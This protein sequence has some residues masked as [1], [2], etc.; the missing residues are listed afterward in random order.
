M[1]AG[2]RVAAIIDILQQLEDAIEDGQRLPADA[3]LHHYTKKRRY[4][5]AKDR[6]EIARVVYLVLRHYAALQYQ[7]DAVGLQPNA[8]TVVLAAIIMLDH[9]SIEDVDVLCEGEDHYCPEVLS[10]K[11]GN[12]LA[13]LQGKPL[14][15]DAQP[16]HVRYNVPA[17]MLPYLDERF[18][19][20]LPQAMKAMAKE[21][22]VD[23]R[24]NTLVT[25]QEKMHYVLEQA[26]FHAH[27]VDLVGTALRMHKRGALFTLPEFQKGWF[28][29]QDAG[30]QYVAH[31]CAVQP[32]EKV[33]DFC[34]GA[35]GK[36]LALAAAMQ[37]KGRIL[38]WDVSPA[39]MR[40]LPRRLKRAGVHNVMVHQ[41]ESEQDS[42]IKRHKQSADCVLV[43]APCTG[44]GT[45]RRAP[46]S[47]W[48]T[49][50]EEIAR[51][52]ELQ[53]RILASAARL[54][55][56]GGRLVYATCSVFIPEN[57]QQIAAFLQAHPH[58]SLQRE[59]H[60][61][62]HTHGTD[63]FYVAVMQRNKVD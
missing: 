24:V 32:G 60:L 34:A 42:F 31:L 27:G 13:S 63:G 52:T 40:D 17:W 28:E 62:P 12:A 44:S 55:K 58:Y 11:E 47:K 37:N 16:L 50:E 9:A 2:A 57:H 18:G 6:G 39:R 53:Q 8:R 48:H 36:T 26:G 3:A 49:H 56:E 4:I 15:H 59:E 41:L 14:Y 38:A 45:W 35:G 43:D 29:M 54:P 30:S 51:I 61:A 46:D 20:A 1:R 10:N 25:N 5:G 33:I 7:V 22:P 21:A 23:I 19:E